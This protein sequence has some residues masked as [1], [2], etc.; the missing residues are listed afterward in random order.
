VTGGR[1]IRPGVDFTVSFLLQENYFA[2]RL[3]APFL[4]RGRVCN[5]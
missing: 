1:P 2:L 4:T 5:L 3:G